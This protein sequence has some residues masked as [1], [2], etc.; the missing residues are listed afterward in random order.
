V[1]ARASRV[2]RLPETYAYHSLFETYAYH[3]L[4]GSTL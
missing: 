3:S 4:F 2:C 1:R